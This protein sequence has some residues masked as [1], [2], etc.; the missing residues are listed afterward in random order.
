MMYSVKREDAS[1]SVKLGVLGPQN[2]VRSSELSHERRLSPQPS[3]K[4]RC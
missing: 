4:T 2:M 1:D 3:V